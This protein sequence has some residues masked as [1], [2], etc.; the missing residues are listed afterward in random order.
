MKTEHTYQS[1]FS[2]RYGSSEMREIWSEYQTRLLWRKLWVSLAE[3]QA[4]FQ[5]VSEEQLKELQSHIA[6]VDLQRSMEIEKQIHHDLMAELQVFA[7][8]CPGAGGIIHMGATSMDIK[9]NALVLQL[10]AAQKLVIIRLGELLLTLS[11]LINTWSDLPLIGFCLNGIADE[12]TCF[13]PNGSANSPKPG[14]WS[15]RR[16][17]ASLFNTAPTPARADRI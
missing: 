8:Q 2:W 13:F 14:D 6:D 4:D 9:D 5:L 16:S 12:P 10:T 17:N 15:N 11:N 3:V 7:D 1:P